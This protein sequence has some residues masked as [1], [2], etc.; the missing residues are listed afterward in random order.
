MNEQHIKISIDAEKNEQEILIAL[1]SEMDFDAFEETDETLTAF[2]KADLF[3]EEQLQN[4]LSGM[5]LK[6]TKEIIEKTNW[7]AVWESNFQPIK[8]D[9]FVGV[10]A[11]FHPPLTGV[12][13]EIIITPKMSFGTGH[14]ATTHLMLAEMRNVDFS[15]KTVIDFGTGTGI[16]AIMAEKLGA[17]KINAIDN[18]TWCIENAGENVERNNCNKI[19]LQL[20]ENL[21]GL[22]VADII[23]ANINKHIILQ[24]LADIKAH[25]IKNGYLLLSG[26]LTEDE[27][28]LIKALT[29]IEIKHIHTTVKN[30]WICMF[31]RFE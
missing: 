17:E 7:N 23:L 30:N 27:P 26:L 16:L 19:Q 2:I 22:Q 13:H 18:D 10:R 14:H 24:N 8:V 21:G 11:D 31:C 9:D 12:E 6:F 4:I 1:L 20:A 15:G 5:Q 25:L 28:D 29:S 3:D